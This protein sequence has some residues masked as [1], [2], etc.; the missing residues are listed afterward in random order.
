MQTIIEKHKE[1]ATHSGESAKLH[2]EAASLHENGDH[3]TADLNT[4]KANEHSTKTT[5]LEKE[6][7]KQHIK[8]LFKFKK[9][10]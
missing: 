3:E 1:A 4:A 9:D 5:K 7:L 6:I 2:Y 10:K 8:G